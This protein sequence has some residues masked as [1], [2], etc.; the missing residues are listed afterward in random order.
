VK[1]TPFVP[2]HGRT[3]GFIVNYSPD[4]AVRFDLDGNPIESFERAYIPGEVE[5]FLGRRRVSTGAFAKVLG[6]EFDR[7]KE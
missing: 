4:H 5:L 7:G 1:K 2:Y 6:I 3:T